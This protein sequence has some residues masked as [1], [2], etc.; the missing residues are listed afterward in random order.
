MGDMNILLLMNKRKAAAGLPGC[1]LFCFLLV[2]SKK[3]CYNPILRAK[4]T[5][6]QT[7]IEKDEEDGS[8]IQKY[9]KQ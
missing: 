1:L 4:A 3:V 6:R 2:D 5:L 9:E 7:M 8:V